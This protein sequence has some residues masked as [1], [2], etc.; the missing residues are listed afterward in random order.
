MHVYVCVCV[1]VF[2][3][4]PSFFFIF[5]NWLPTR[6]QRPS[7]SLTRMSTNLLVIFRSTRSGHRFLRPT[8]K[9]RPGHGRTLYIIIYYTHR[10]I[11]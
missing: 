11:V 7:S 6:E 5:F 4:E 2:V 8:N 3:R 1:C 9:T 10:N